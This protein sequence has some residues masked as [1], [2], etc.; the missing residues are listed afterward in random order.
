[1][2]PAA[3][4]VFRPETT[5]FDSPGL[6]TRLWP[7]TVPVL[8]SLTLLFDLRTTGAGAAVLPSAWPLVAAACESALKCFLERCWLPLT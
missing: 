4:L 2:L 5:V 1:M 7:S 8:P 3:E 6:F